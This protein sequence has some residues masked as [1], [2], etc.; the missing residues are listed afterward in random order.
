MFANRTKW[1]LSCNRLAM[2][3]E[4]LR[5]R[6]CE[7]LD[8]TAS[9]P[10]DCG[11][12]YD[13]SSILKALITPAVLKYH[14]DPRGLQ[15]ARIAVQEY[16][17]RRNERVSVDDLILTTSTSEAYSFVFRLL[18]N[19][20]D[21]VLVPTPSY[22]LFDFL[23]DIQ[24][25]KLVRYPLVYDHGWQIDFHALETA[26]TPRTRAVIVVHPN[27]PTGHFSKAEELNR[28]N[29]ICAAHD[30]AII[31]DEVFLDFSLNTGNH[32]SFTQNDLSL[33]F[34]MSGISKISGL[35]QMKVA[36]LAVSGPATKKGEALSR[37]EVIADTFLSMNAAIQAAAPTLLAQRHGFQQQ[38]M[39]RVR[40]NVAELDRQLSDQKVC[41][42][43][44]IEGG[45]YAVI[46][47]PAIRSDEELALELLEEGVYLHPGHFYDF[48]GEGY[49][50][51]SLIARERTFAE[52]IEK[53]L[54]HF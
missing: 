18:C 54:A 9:N 38:L 31:A 22:P 37:L 15:S 16:Y 28:L 33:T 17:E 45:W 40:S 1:N 4:D 36:W 19:P 7:L 42:R 46:R 41:T 13:G 20:G 25:V 52:G 44:E 23:A 24:D 14:P 34:T 11:F 51:V 26:I 47:V 27:N 35:P 29:Q 3:L 5:G 39:A 50:V 21:E 6:G 48:P 49:L 30:L 2:V 8:L 12:Q 53:L 32:N 43:L 10:T